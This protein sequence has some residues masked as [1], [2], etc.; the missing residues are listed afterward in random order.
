MKSS[1]LLSC[2]IC[3]SVFTKAQVVNQL[4]IYPSSPTS[5]DSIYIV[6]DFSYYGNCAYGLVSL[7]TFLTDTTIHI[8][9]TY[10]GYGDPTLCNSIDTFVVGPYPAGH[11]AIVIEYHQ[12]SI[13]PLSGF[14]ALIANADTSV[15]INPPAGI[16]SALTENNSLS[17]FPNPVHN[18]LYLSCDFNSIE[19]SSLEILNVLGEIVMRMNSIPHVINTEKLENGMYVLIIQNSDTK[20]TSPFIILR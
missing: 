6:S 14:D 20:S 3:L 2:F 10:C 18:S 13:C 17:L 11:Y 19:S 16:G 9:P 8:V 4:Q 12:G 1:I 15:M 5:S 7:Y